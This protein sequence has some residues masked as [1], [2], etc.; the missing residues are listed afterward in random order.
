M[1]YSQWL[2][3]GC[4]RKCCHIGKVRLPWPLP[5]P[6]ALSLQSSAVHKSLMHYIPQARLFPKWLMFQMIFSCSPHSSWAKLSVWNPSI[7][8][9]KLSWSKWLLL[10]EYLYFKRRMF[11]TDETLTSEVFL[12]SGTFVMLFLVELPFSS[13]PLVSDLAPLTS[14]KL[15]NLALGQIVLCLSYSRKHPKA[16]CV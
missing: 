8:S 14:E 1:N 7:P 5:L 3:A 15:S 13:L 12:S 4:T 9:P 6:G 16:P 10:K 11:N 2:L